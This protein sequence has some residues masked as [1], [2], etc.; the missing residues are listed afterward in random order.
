MYICAYI[1]IYIY[2]TVRI[3][4]VYIGMHICAHMYIY[5]SAYVN[6]YM[7]M[8]MRM[9]VYVYMCICRM[10]AYRRTAHEYVYVC[11]YAGVCAG[12]CVY[13]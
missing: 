12:W 7:Y 6:G 5:P 4:R 1:Y 10:N 2:T 3:W 9:C 11:T 8:H 13:M